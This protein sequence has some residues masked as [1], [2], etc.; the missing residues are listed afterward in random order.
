[1]LPWPPEKHQ[2][3]KCLYIPP[4]S[5]PGRS[6]TDYLGGEVNICPLSNESHVHSSE[7]VSS[8]NS[9]LPLCTGENGYSLTKPLQHYIK[10]IT[11]KGGGGRYFSTCQQFFL[12]HKYSKKK[13]NHIQQ[14]AYKSLHKNAGQCARVTTC[15]AHISQHACFQREEIAGRLLRC[16]AWPEVGSLQD[17]EIFSFRFT[18]VV[19]SWKPDILFFQV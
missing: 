14:A 13:K 7:Q 12:S 2:L 10:S 15:R 17:F 19:G 9:V 5:Q 4:D 8:D 3:F 1:M 11:F 6:I 16:S 18:Q